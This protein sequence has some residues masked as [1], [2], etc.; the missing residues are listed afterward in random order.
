MAPAWERPWPSLASWQGGLM[1]APGIRDPTWKEP[2][3][4]APASPSPSHISESPPGNSTAGANG[5]KIDS[6]LPPFGR[7]H[8]TFEKEHTRPTRGFKRE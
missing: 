2:C 5:E 6:L 1:S 4:A 8:R 3:Q 7:R